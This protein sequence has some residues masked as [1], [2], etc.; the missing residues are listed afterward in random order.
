MVERAH[1]VK[2]YGVG[3]IADAVTPEAIA[4]AVKELATPEKLSQCR[5]NCK[6]AAQELT[7]ENEEKVLEEVYCF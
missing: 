2:Q 1:I 7:W 5:E 3:V 6:T 4:K